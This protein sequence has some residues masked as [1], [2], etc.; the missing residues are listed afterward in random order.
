ME[1]TEEPI[2]LFPPLPAFEL[3]LVPALPPEPT[4]IV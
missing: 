4:V 3:T 2:E 1:T